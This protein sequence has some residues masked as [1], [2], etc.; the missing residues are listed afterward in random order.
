M[1]YVTNEDSDNISVINRQTGDVV[2]SIMVGKKPRG[3]ALS[4]GG[5]RLRVYVVNSGTNDIS[6]IDPTTNK[7]VNEIPLRFGR[8]PEGIALVRI[9]PEKEFL[10]VTN[11]ESNSL[12]IVN[13]VT[14]QETDKVD[15][16][17]GPVA[18]AAD[19]S[20]S[21]LSNARSLSLND[22][23]ELERYRDSFFNIYVANKNSNT[24]SILRMDNI[25]GRKEEVIT[26]DVEWNPIALAVDYIRGKVY[27]ANHGSDKLSIIDILE[28]NRGNAAGAVGVIN[29]VGTAVIG[30]V[31]DTIFDRVYL[32]REMP[33]EVMVIRT[34]ARQ[35]HSIRSE[36]T[37]VM[38][39]IPVG[40]FPRS[41]AIDPEIRKLY[42]VNRGSD[43]ITVIDKTTKQL[44]QT[45]PVGRK[46]YGIAMFSEGLRR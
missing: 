6:V 4:E 25:S 44:E 27:V 31:P 28:V 24:V 23:H 16:G 41:I 33:G 38:G 26:V 32:L 19:P 36:L 22:I 29:N 12:S 1:A 17:I 11:Y 14:L 10:Y 8:G 34:P 30:I 39:M 3:I 5:D 43:T 45:I 21:V 35:N 37:P 46:P 15:V 40:R 9:S 18:V 2:A 13:A 7:I 20:V 42:V